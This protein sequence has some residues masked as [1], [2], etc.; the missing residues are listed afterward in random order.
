MSG[1]IVQV[2]GSRRSIMKDEHERDVEAYGLPAPLMTLA[3]RPHGRNPMKVVPLWEGG[4]VLG[5]VAH[6][7]NEA[8]RRRAKGVYADAEK[9]DIILVPLYRG[10]PH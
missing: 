2:V 1:P 6:F 8:A 9:A 5:N 3:G 4:Q 10:K 7:R